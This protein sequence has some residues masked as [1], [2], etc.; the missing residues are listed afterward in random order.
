MQMAKAR[1]WYTP[2]S[3]RRPLIIW[4]KSAL[5]SQ[6]LSKT[7]KVSINFQIKNKRVWKQE[8]STFREKDHASWGGNKLHEITS[9]WIVRNVQVKKGHDKIGGKR[10][11]KDMLGEITTKGPLDTRSWGQRWTQIKWSYWCSPIINW[12]LLFTSIH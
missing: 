1:V 12:P 11:G 2:R 3:S 9:N 5:F 4:T 7:H 8:T 10:A 6:Q